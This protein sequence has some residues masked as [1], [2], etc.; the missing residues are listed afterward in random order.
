M[1][2]VAKNST[3]ARCR[4]CDVVVHLFARW[5]FLLQALVN[6]FNRLKQHVTT[7][8]DHSL[9]PSEG[10]FDLE[11]ATSWSAMIEVFIALKSKLTKSTDGVLLFML[12]SYME[13]LRAACE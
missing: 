3:R 12:Q 2:A 8:T 10:A 4:L 11:L 9:T 5:L 13:V 1:H 6:G 7:F